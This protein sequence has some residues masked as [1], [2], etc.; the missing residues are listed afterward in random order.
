M[1]I[2]EG[3]RLY[4]TFTEAKQVADR[5]ARTHNEGF[6]PYKV[7]SSW[8]VGGVHMK[9]RPK[10]VKAFDDLRKL[11][12]E[13]K[14]SEEDSSVED[15]FNEIEIASQTNE[16]VTKGDSE[17]WILKSVALKKGYELGMSPSNQSVYLALSVQNNTDTLTLKMGGKFSPHIPL[18][19]RLSES[20][21]TQPVIWHTWNSTIK[22]TNWGNEEWFYAIQ[23]NAD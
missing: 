1:N 23:L 7:G 16:S 17:I 11:L 8:A 20:L 12:N 4:S 9:P 3:K 10:K 6:E 15:Y 19:K 14:D 13:F 22:K 18:I 5:M 21:I 2:D